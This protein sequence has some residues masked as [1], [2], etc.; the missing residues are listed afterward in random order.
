MSNSTGA[1]TLGTVAPA[2][3][4]SRELPALRLIVAAERQ[5]QLGRDHAI[6]DERRID[7]AQLAEA[8][9]EEPRA[10]DEHERQGDLDD[11]QRHARAALA[12][13]AADGFPR[14]LEYRDEI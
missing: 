14:A 12:D 6:G 2:R 1:S 7:P 9:Q 4:F 3:R 8:A 10:D 13:R 5:V 11:G